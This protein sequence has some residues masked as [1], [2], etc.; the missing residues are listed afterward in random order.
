MTSTIRAHREDRA[1][2]AARPVA[3]GQAAD[4]VIAQAVEHQRDQLP[5]GGDDADVAAAA[6]ADPVAGLPEAGV[7]GHALHGLDR[8]PAHQPAALFICGTR[9]V[10]P[11]GAR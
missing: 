9:D 5:G 10:N 4:V 2:H 1:A 7:R 6:F 8:G 3:G 11:A